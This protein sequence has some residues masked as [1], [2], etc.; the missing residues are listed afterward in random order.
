M[1]RFCLL[2]ALPLASLLY[3]QRIQLDLDHLAKK[4][5]KSE[6]VNVDPS[7]MEAGKAFMHQDGNS[8][9]TAAKIIKGMQTIQVRSFQFDKPGAFTNADIER[10]RR[11][12][13]GPGWSRLVSDTNTRSGRIEEVYLHSTEGKSD[14]MVVLDVKPT[15]LEVVNI[16][17]SI[18]ANALAGADSGQVK[19]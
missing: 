8:N 10:I 5:S 17:G 3:G 4:A 2:I 16:I 15:K 9:R 11:Q 14:G 6:N 12:L 18:D 19:Q 13:R 1:M 7:M